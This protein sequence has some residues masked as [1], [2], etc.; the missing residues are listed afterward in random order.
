[1]ESKNLKQGVGNLALPDGGR[2]QRRGHLSHT[3]KDEEEFAR[4]PLGTVFLSNKCVY[5]LVCLSLLGYYLSPHCS[6]GK[7]MP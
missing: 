7:Q 3:L 4:Q 6:C 5:K 2:P 1:M